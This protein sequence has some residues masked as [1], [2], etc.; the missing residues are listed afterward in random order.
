[1]I[2]ISQVQS[3]D[4]ATTPVLTHET[5]K[6]THFFL[7][8]EIQIRLFGKITTLLSPHRHCGTLI[9]LF[10]VTHAIIICVKPFQFIKRVHK[11]PLVHQTPYFV[12]L[13]RV[14]W[15]LQRSRGRRPLCLA[16]QR[17]TFDGMGDELPSYLHQ[18][19]RFAHTQL[20]H[21]NRLEHVF[22]SQ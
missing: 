13:C 4:N 3:Q 17:D 12:F 20:E 14:P 2:I 9:K 1:M 16:V 5:H 11:L 10:F 19:D 15:T 21:V 6:Y 7:I 8:S 22:S 18:R